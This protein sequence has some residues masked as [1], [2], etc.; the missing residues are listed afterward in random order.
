MGDN[1]DC[2]DENPDINP[3]AEEICDGVDNDCDGDIDEDVPGD[4]ETWYADAD[5]DGWADED[6]TLLA[7]EQPSGYLGADAL[8]DCDDEDATINPD[9]EEVCDLLDND[10]NGTIDGADATDASTWYVDADSDGFGND[11]RSTPDCVQPSGFVA[12]GGDCDDLDGSINPDAEEFCDE[13]DNDCDGDVD[14][15]AALDAST[16]YPDADGDRYGDPDSGLAAC[17]QPSGYLTDASD[18]DD[19][20]ASTYPGATEY[21]DGHDDDCDGDVDEDSAV[22]ASTWYVDADA[23]GYGSADATTV[24]CN[25]PSGFEVDT[26]DCDDGDA[27]VYPGASETW[28]DGVDSDCAGDDDYDQDADGDQHED[29]GGADCDDGDASISSLVAESWYDGVDQD[30]DGLSDYD[31]DYDTYDSDAYGGTDCDDGDATVY[32]GADEVD[33]TVDNDCDGDIEEAPVVVAT[34]DSSSTL[35]HCSALYLDGSGS[36]DPDGTAL[37]YDW[38]VDTVPSGSAIDDS[39]FDA[40]ASATPVVYPDID[41]DYEFQLSI[42]D[43]GD[44]EV[45]TTIAVTVTFR[46]SNTAP[47]VDAGDDATVSDSVTCTASGYSYVCDDCASYVYALDGTGTYDDDDEPLEYLWTVLSGSASLTDDDTTS[48]SVTLTGPSCT[49][50]ATTTETF[51]IEL[52]VTDCYG[53]VS[54]DS[55]YLYY[56]CTGS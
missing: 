25:Q 2:D 54:T 13:V 17:E 27:S 47:W 53:A 35:E 15:G 26:S 28:Y 48:P 33:G 36:Y 52:E 12:T 18:C 4:A 49:Y 40:A 38:T 34:Y 55:I 14:E 45:S 23:D 3:D 29:H 1:T 8:G 41:G 39:S 9:G 16:W 21:C 42:T 10:C 56:V 44:I 43:Q 6:N 46:A 19:G 5:G 24:A 30:C 22:D 37:T 51:E 20:D 7:C 50:G 32:P 11:D 31:A